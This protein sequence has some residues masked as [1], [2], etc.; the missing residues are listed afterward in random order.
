MS[1]LHEV[2]VHRW[3]F[4]HDVL[5]A[6]GDALACEAGLQGRHGR[7]IEL[8]EL[9]VRAFITGIQAL[10]DND[11]TGGTGAYPSTDMLQFDAV[12]HRNVE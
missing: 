2:L 10:F 9:I 11:M 5:H 1:F 4:H 6:V 12:S 7:L 3:N 8:I